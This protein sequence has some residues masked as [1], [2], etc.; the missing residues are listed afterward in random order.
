MKTDIP[1]MQH[2]GPKLATYN[3]GSSIG[4]TK[5]HSQTGFLR[6]SLISALDARGGGGGDCD[7]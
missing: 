6:S 1:R 5:I 7:L 4:R 3:T 2:G